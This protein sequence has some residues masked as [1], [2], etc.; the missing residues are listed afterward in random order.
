MSLLETLSI[1]FRKDVFALLLRDGVYAKSVIQNI[2]EDFF[3]KVPEYDVLFQALKEFFK[4]YNTRPRI[5]ELKSYVARATTKKGLD[6][7]TIKLIYSSLK[8]SVKNN[9]FTPGYVKDRL[10]QAIT[11]HHMNNVLVNA[12]SMIDKGEFDELL[13]NMSKARNSGIEHEELTEYWSD[14]EDRIDR[15]NKREHRVV[16]TGWVILDGLTQHGGMPRG[17]INIVMAPTGRGKTALLGDIAL[18]ASELGY[19]GGYISLEI[20]KDYLMDRMDANVSGVPLSS[21]QVVPNKIK[22]A[23][24]TRYLTPPS[25]D[26]FVGPL[27]VQYFPTKSISI[28]DVEAFLERIRIEY[29]FSLDY[30]MV[31]YF[32]LMK[33]ESLTPDSKDYKV[34]EE[35]MER[36][37]G[38]AGKYDMAIWTG[39]QTNRG[40]V[41]KEDISMGDIA[42]SYGKLFPAD[43]L[44]VVNQSQA[45]KK[46]GV[47]RI[48]IEKSRVSPIGDHFWVKPYWEKM[49]FSFFDEEEAIKQGITSKEESKKAKK[50]ATSSF[51]GV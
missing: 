6:E 45:E 30:L 14:T 5:K 37:R 33:M 38:V 44:M 48:S 13:K 50:A 10:S 39:S 20:Y 28:S 23:I 26:K 32:D 29:G 36:L 9:S 1:D 25:E 12:G 43:F 34:L 16:P 47:F 40:G 21:L 15:R 22:K 19:C 11:T 51:M 3:G 49:Q 41:T 2:P 27:F 17:S 24:T 7:E 46:K 31:D 18:R 8:E 35:N 4:D 42:S